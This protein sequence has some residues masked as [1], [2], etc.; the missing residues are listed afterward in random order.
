[1]SADSLNPKPAL[2]WLTYLLLLPLIALATIVFGCVSLLAGL[3]D[4]SGRQQHAIARAWANVLLWISLSPVN[5]RQ[6][7]QTKGQR[8]GCLRSEP[9]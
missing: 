2:R 4:K 9:S 5:P 1:M 6:L 7:Q 8:S 3:W